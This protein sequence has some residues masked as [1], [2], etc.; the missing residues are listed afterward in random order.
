MGGELFALGGSVEA[1]QLEAKEL[2]ARASRPFKLVSFT[3]GIGSR[4]KFAKAVG[5][6]A[7]RAKMRVLKRVKERIV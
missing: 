6:T 4:S 7:S 2:T 1:S 3:M 5:R